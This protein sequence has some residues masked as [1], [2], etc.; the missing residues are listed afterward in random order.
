ML[1]HRL[2]QLEVFVPLRHDPGHAQADFGEAVA[3]IAGVE[4]KIHFFAVDKSDTR[5]DTGDLG[6][7]VSPSAS[8]PIRAAASRLASPDGMKVDTEGNVYCGGTAVHDA[9][10]LFA[11]GVH[12]PDAAAPATTNI[13][14]GGDDWK[15]LYFT[16]RKHLGA[17]NVKIPGIPVP[18]A[19]NSGQA[20]PRRLEPSHRCAHREEV[21]FRTADF[22]GG[23]VFFRGALFGVGGLRAS[24]TA[25]PA[26]N[27]T[28]WL[29][30]IW[31]ASPVC[32]FRPSRAG[33]AATLKMPSPETRTASPATRA[34]RMA[35]TTAFT[36][37]PAAAWLS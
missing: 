24:L 32:G 15:T 21:Y 2:R 34:S 5:P 9:P 30:A 22:F 35:F 27:R 29:A 26:W 8:P 4:R 37:W 13:A 17:V 16:S 33:R 18:V 14:F 28:A 23:A 36:A 20:L 7:A 1:A 11:L 31:M 19:K 25:L 3:E 10:E 6:L 12:D